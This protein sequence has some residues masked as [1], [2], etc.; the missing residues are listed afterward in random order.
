VYESLND[1]DATAQ[2]KSWGYAFGWLAGTS[3]IGAGWQLTF[4]SPAETKG[5]FSV[6]TR[7]VLFID[8]RDE[9]DEAAWAHAAC[10]NAGYDIGKTGF[11][12]RVAWAPDAVLFGSTGAPL[13][14][15][16]AT[17]E[18]RKD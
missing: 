17:I 1:S 11:G 9:E 8:T 3:M 12:I 6:G 4:A 2:D 14:S 18:A 10:A 7:V 13:L 5:W 16:L 15:V